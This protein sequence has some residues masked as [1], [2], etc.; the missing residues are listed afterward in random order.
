MTTDDSML[1]IAASEI[2]HKQT[3]DAFLAMAALVRANR[4]FVDE[5]TYYTR[6]DL[7]SIFKGYAELCERTGLS[8]A[9]AVGQVAEE[10]GWLTSWW[11]GRPRRNPAGIGVTG[12]KSANPMTV[13]AA[14]KERVGRWI[15]GNSFESWSLAATAHVGRLLA[16][17]YP[18][19][20]VL[21]PTAIGCIDTALRHRPLPKK[22]R[23]CALTLRD[24]GIKEN[25]LK[26]GWAESPGYG[27]KV[28]DKIRKIESFA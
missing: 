20:T 26:V 13:P 22:A 16:Y 15:A 17:R 4:E 24:L 12:A 23:G 6:P 25:P 8:F 2:T 9:V 21:N 10:T 1:L 14:F 27:E 3:V 19:G 18:E 28:A 7:N 5:G 11:A